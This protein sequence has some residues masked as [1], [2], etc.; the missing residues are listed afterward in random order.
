MRGVVEIDQI[1]LRGE[2]VV[3]ER[4]PVHDQ[5]LTVRLVDRGRDRKGAHHAGAPMRAECGT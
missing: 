3:I 1:R 5:R 4:V 2:V